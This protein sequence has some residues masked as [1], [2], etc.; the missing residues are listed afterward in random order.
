MAARRLALTAQILT[1]LA[2][3]ALCA[4][5][6][7][8]DSDHSYTILTVS[9]DHAI[10]AD[11]AAH[12]VPHGYVK[13]TLLTVPGLEKAAYQISQVEI[14]CSAS[15]L[16]DISAVPYRA[17]GTAMAGTPQDPTP[18]PIVAGTVGEAIQKYTCEGADPYPRSKA[19][20]GIPAAMDKAKDLIAQFVK[21]GA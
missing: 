9:K 11:E 12:M 19:L 7:A 2:L 14:S 4:P 5:V 10:F 21:K 8:A 17:D 18:K 1:A 6:L 13:L 20:T 3:A 15:L 16:I